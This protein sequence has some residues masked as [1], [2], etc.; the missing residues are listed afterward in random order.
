MLAKRF[1]ASCIGGMLLTSACLSAEK[2]PVIHG[3]KQV[4][5]VRPSPW[6]DRLLLFALQKQVEGESAAY[7]SGP[8]VSVSIIGNSW[9]SREIRPIA[10]DM[11][12]AN[13]AWAK[14]SAFVTSTRAVFRLRPGALPQKIYSGKPAGLA[15][16]RDGMFLAFWQ[17]SNKIDTL[18]VLRLSDRRVIRQW[19]RPYHLKTESSG[20]D[21]AFAPDGNTV[22]ARTYDE[23]DDNHLKSFNI[24]TGAMTT[25]L[26]GC[27]SIVQS[28]DRIFVFG[29]QGDAKGL[30]EFSGERPQLLFH[31]DD[32]D[33]LTPTANSS[34]VVITH[35]FKKHLIIYDAEH[36]AAQEF[37][38]CS[39]ATVLKSGQQLFFRDGKILLDASECSR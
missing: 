37:D 7:V 22:L 14:G 5:S 13:I 31:S 29:G 4:F 11:D 3:A 15:V 23:E 19:K 1:V 20:W 30:Y 18:V 36:K 28:G 8:L 26:E 21:L 35:A 2:D 27:N 33:S 9:R 39:D 32:E 38:G 25:L 10:A 16:S 24:R 12:S 34:V 6:E 17:F